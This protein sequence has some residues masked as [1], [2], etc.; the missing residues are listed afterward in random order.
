MADGTP[1]DG[2]WTYFLDSVRATYEAKEIKT[3]FDLIGIYQSAR[4]DD[5]FPTLNANPSPEHS[6]TPYY[7]TEQ[8]ESGLIA[9]ASN[10]SIKNT[11]LDGFFI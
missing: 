9:Y 3:K 1:G 2:S 4:P 7:L 6:R 8:N 11:T 10:K 5:W